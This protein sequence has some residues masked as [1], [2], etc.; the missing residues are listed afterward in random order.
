MPEC[1]IL[2]LF[3]EKRA[4]ASTHASNFKGAIY[5]FFKIIVFSL[6]VLLLLYI[7]H[8]EKFFIKRFSIEDYIQGI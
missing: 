7:S 5:R 2:T 8:K 1:V 3:P 6:F 4:R